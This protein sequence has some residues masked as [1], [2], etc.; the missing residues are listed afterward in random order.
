M[1]SFQCC[2]SRFL[3]ETCSFKHLDQSS[4]ALLQSWSCPLPLE[5]PPRMQRFLLDTWSLAASAVSGFCSSAIC[6]LELGCETGWSTNH[7]KITSGLM[8]TEL[9]CWWAVKSTWQVRKT[10]RAIENSVSVPGVGR[11]RIETH[12]SSDGFPCIS[13]NLGK[14]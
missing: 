1:G 9:K 2:I 4:G 3:L 5:F 14:C 13:C 10:G 12:R 8:Q 11:E 7:R 6:L